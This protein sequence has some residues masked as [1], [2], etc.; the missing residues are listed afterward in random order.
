MAP[1][2][3]RTRRTR[4]RRSWTTPTAGSGRRCVPACPHVCSTDAGTPFNPHGNAPN[5]IARMVEWGMAAAGGARGRR[6][7]NGAT[8]LRIPDVGTI[9][10]G[11]PRRPGRCTTPIP[12]RTSR[13][14]GRPAPCGRVGSGSSDPRHPLDQLGATADVRQLLARETREALGER[15][16]ALSS[17]LREDPLA[18]GRR[19]R[20]G[21][22]ARRPDR[23]AAGRNRRA[24][25]RRPGGSSW[26]PP[27]PRPP[28]ARRSRWD[29]RRRRPR[30][31]TAGEGRRRAR[32]PPCAGDATGAGPP[33]GADRRRP[34]PLAL[35]KF[36][37]TRSSVCLI[38]LLSL[39]KYRA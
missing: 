31:R 23:P 37:L 30:A 18:R 6:R 5:E 9:A 20:P 33:S 38:Y 21:R 19:A 28:P 36:A 25:G 27:R 4:R 8:L 29:R 1:G 14:S 11:L 24:P 7:R 26:V 32:R 2:C 16:D 17:S 13:R 39:S 22:P 15:A 12:S 35:G 10:A 3:R 34:R